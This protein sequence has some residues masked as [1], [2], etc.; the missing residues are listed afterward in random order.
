M[1]RGLLITTP[2][3]QLRELT[4]QDLPAFYAYA[5]SPEVALFQ[6]SSPWSAEE[7]REYLDFH[8]SHQQE[9]GRTI[10]LLALVFPDEQRLIGTCSLHVRQL[11]AREAELGYGL[12]PLYWGNGYAT[13]ATRALL[14]CAFTQLHLHRVFAL[15]AAANLPSAR[16]MQKIGMQQEGRLRDHKFWQDQWHDSLLYSILASEFKN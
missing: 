13:E 12:H 4:L 10:F 3:L 2:R 1:S 8:L 11:D 16:V 15:C 14:H 9:E 7:C 6:H 5:S